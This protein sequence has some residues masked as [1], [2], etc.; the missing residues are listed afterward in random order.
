MSTASSADRRTGIDPITFEVLR[1]KMWQITD[2]MGMTLVHTSG[3]PVVTEVMDFATA[4]FTADGEIVSMGAYVMLHL[5]AM[6][7]AVK[8]VI[9]ECGDEPG[10]EPDDL[11]ILND[12]YRGALHQSDVDIVAPIHYDGELIG[13]AGCMCHQLDVGG[14]LP[15]GWGAGAT[16]VY[17]E[18]LRLSPIKFVER[19]K[20]RRDIWNAIL[21][22]IRL[23]EVGLD[24]KAQIAAD[25][26]AKKRLVDLCATYGVDT[27]KEMMN[28][29]IDYSEIKLREK[30]LA[31]P[32]GTY[33]HVDYE[34]HDGLQPNIYQVV[35]TM[36]K[37]GDQLT[38]DF[39]GTSGQAPGFINCTYAGTWGGFCVGLLPALCYDIPWNAGLMRPVELI[40]PEGTVTNPKV[41]APVSMA[42]VATTWTVRNASQAVFSKM[43]GCSNDQW[44]DAMAVWEGGIPVLVIA[45]LNQFNE[46]YGYLIMDIVSGGCGA[47][48][49]RDGVDSAG[50][51]NGP[52]LA[53][54]NIETH[55]AVY[56]ILYAFRRQ[57][58]DTGGPG[59]F[60]GGV[61]CEEMFTPYGVE[62]V[63]MT[64]GAHGVEL[65]NGAGI[66]GGYPGSTN[67]VVVIH[68]ANVN[69]MIKAGRLPQSLSEAKGVPEVLPACLPSKWITNGEFLYFRWEGAGG[70]GDPIDRDP[71][72]VLR[73]VV[74]DLVFPECARD[75]YG[76]VIDPD[77]MAVDASATEGRRAELRQERLGRAVESGGAWGGEHP[78]GARRLG[79]YLRSVV[80][81]GRSVV[82]CAKCGHA[83]GPTGEN[84]KLHAVVKER[85]LSV[86]GPYHPADEKTRFCL[87]EFYCPECATRF[88]VEV[89]RKGTPVIFDV[90][91]LV[92]SS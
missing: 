2:E 47:T 30:L 5:A 53:M 25:N 9:E 3:S 49:T 68:E 6:Q 74:N 72:A 54:P 71:G 34:D 70:Y 62:R 20:L 4:I 57:M 67:Q 88:E 66:Y 69:D 37:K 19:G 12:P 31:L 29:L 45:G 27:V 58:R 11:F 21:N 13:W 23:P 80:T 1:H 16:E 43:F 63:H 41:P 51:A 40:A 44:Q 84:P 81:G 86:A 33:R 92:T 24:F 75:I 56:P 48:A 28:R 22:N 65:P 39:T 8:S 77:R 18:A 15:G 17:Q 36:T 38:A 50:D 78:Q 14:I 85:P 35:L 64:T 76:V 90:E 10:I 46:P 52:T 59:K 60:R 42:S 83:Y 61:S 89:I 55:E 79:E 73:D 32:D 82:R 26:V 7:L 91:P 87:R